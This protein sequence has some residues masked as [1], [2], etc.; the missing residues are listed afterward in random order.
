MREKARIAANKPEA[1]KENSAFRA[2]K[3]GFSQSINSSVDH[4]LFLQR[5]IG[6]QAVQRLFKSGAL[7][8]KL[9][10]G[11]AGDRYEQEAERVAEQVMRMPEPQV[12]RQVEPEEEFQTKSAGKRGTP[13]VSKGVHS[14]ID[15]LRGGGQPLPESARAFFEPRF[16]HDFS[17]VRVHTGGRAAETAKAINA[18]AFTVGRDVVFGAGKYA[19]ETPAGRRLL[20][21]ELT[22]VVQ[23]RVRGTRDQ[24]LAGIT[25]PGDALEEQGS[26]NRHRA[27]FKNALTYTLTQMATPSASFIQCH[28]DLF[29]PGENYY[30]TNPGQA[31]IAALAKATELG[32][33]HTIVHHPIPTIGQPHYHILGPTGFRGHF[34][35]GRRRPRKEKTKREYRERAK[36]REAARRIATATGVGAGIG[37]VLGGIIGA[38]GGGT[39]GTL[40]APGVGTVGGGVAGGAAGATYGAAVGGLVGGAVMG[41]AQALWE[42]LK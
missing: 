17:G 1:N 27:G 19:P 6:N 16:V 34:F 7:H 9:K 26:I 13:Q 24:R 28:I 20:A 3:R 38:L 5:T 37:M 30:F 39:G 21:H 14:Q 29:I 42:W 2:Q 35:Y 12:Q 22:H 40:V 18:K 8:A 33:G 31:R 41:G 32:P 23:Q 15:S 11:R 10:V 4:I 25:S 36:R